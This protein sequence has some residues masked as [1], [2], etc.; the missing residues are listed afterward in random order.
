MCDKLHTL[1]K[2]YCWRTTIWRS[3]C[4]YICTLRSPRPHCRGRAVG[5]PRRICR[6]CRICRVFFAG[7]RIYPYLW[8][9]IAS[10]Q[11]RLIPEFPV[12]GIQMELTSAKIRAPFFLCIEDKI[13]IVTKIINEP[14]WK[15]VICHFLPLTEVSSRH[16]FFKTR[17]FQVGSTLKNLLAQPVLNWANLR[18]QRYPNPCWFSKFLF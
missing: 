9:A 12:C 11:G 15:S 5:C 14:T 13:Y 17:L 6:I 4:E 2:P 3:R 10:C 1:G 8:V 18:L 16:K 7:L